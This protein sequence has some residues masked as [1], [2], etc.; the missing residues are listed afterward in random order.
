MWKCL[1][2]WLVFGLLGQSTARSLHPIRQNICPPEISKIIVSI[3]E[4][5]IVYPVYINT[6]VTSQTTIIINNGLLSTLLLY[7]HKSSKQDWSQ[8]RLHLRGQ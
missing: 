7:R 5:V 1:Q 3:I 8:Q 4:E 6:Y 2:H